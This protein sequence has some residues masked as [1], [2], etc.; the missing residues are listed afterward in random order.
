VEI[1]A[2]SNR[3]GP[4]HGP[5][6]D[7]LVGT[8]AMNYG[9]VIP[10]SAHFEVLEDSCATCHMQTIA[11][12]NSAWLQAGGHTFSMVAS[13]GAPAV[14][15]CVECHGNIKS[16]DFPRQDYDGDGVVEGVQT[17][18]KGLLAKLQT[19]LPPIGNPPEEVLINNKW[20]R[21]QLRAGYNY[22]FV[23]ED[24]SY[25]IHNL[26]Y[27]VGL[28]KTS[29]ADMSGDANTDGMND[30]WQIQY[31]GSTSNPNAAP[32]ATPAGDGVPNWLKYGL[33]LDPMVKGIVLPDG[34]IYA[35]GGKVGGTNNVVQI[36]TAAEV[37]YNTEVGKTYQL[38]AI[39]SLDGG[40]KN[41]GD[42]VAGNGNAVSLVTPTRS[43]QQQ[44]YRVKITP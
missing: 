4:H 19:L 10:S 9:K 32:N 44:F 41:V 12:T 22:L 23:V 15:I 3:Y 1:T 21:Q 33:G 14:G 36:Y 18:V 27:T 35:N 7:M 25:G 2:G 20:T 34:V 38:Q 39:S 8:N 16:F 6:T 40:W 13:N 29:I 17:E 5:Q 24:G 26:A 11:S 43:N 37:V 42:A 31:F 28:L 30:A